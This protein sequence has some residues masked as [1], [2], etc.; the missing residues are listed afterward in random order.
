MRRQKSLLTSLKHAVCSPSSNFG[1]REVEHIYLC[2]YSKIKLHREGGEKSLKGTTS[3]LHFCLDHRKISFFNLS[4]SSRPCFEGDFQ[5][6]LIF[7]EEHWA[8]SSETWIPVLA[9]LPSQ[10][11]QLVSFLTMASEDE[12]R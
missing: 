9:S 10:F 3:V 1:C 2:T 6:H 12:I 11:S 4:L 8:G 7:Y 5:N